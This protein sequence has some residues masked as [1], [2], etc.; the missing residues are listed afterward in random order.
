MAFVVSE[1]MPWHEGENKMHQLTKVGDFDNP[2]S[3]FLQPRAA[4]MVQR[5]PLLAIGTLDKQGRPWAT[6]WGG[7]VPLAQQVAKDIIGIRTI[8]DS[9]TDPVVQ[10][11]YEGKDDGEVIHEQGAGRMISGLSIHLEQRNRMKLFG[12]MVAGAL[13]THEEGLPGSGSVG[14]IQLVVHIEQSLANCPKYLNCKR[15]RPSLPEP[16]L[17]SDSPHL[18]QEA[19][20]LLEK[21]DLFFISSSDHDKDM[22][23]NH[24]GGPPGFVRVESNG[25]QGA[26]LVYPEYSG[27]NLYQTL[28]NLQTSPRAGLCFPDFDTGDVLYVTG[29]TEVLIGKDAAAVLP[30]SY[31]AV[32]IT[33]TGARFV[34]KGLP[35]KGETLE[36]SPYNPTVRYLPSEKA[37]VGD[38]RSVMA[39][40]I[41]NEKL[42]PT[43]FRVRSAISD[44]GAFGPWKP[45]QYAAL[46][47]YDELYMGYS[48]MRN[49]DPKSLNDDYLRT[50]TVSS[51]HGEGLHGEE[52][53]MTIRNVGHVTGFLARQNER[54]HLEVSLRGFAGDFIIDQKPEGITPFIAGGIGIT[55][56]IAQLQDLDISRLRLFWTLGVRDIGLVHDTFRRFPTLP[57]STALFLTGDASLLP[58]ADKKNLEEVGASGAKVE[59]RRMLADDLADLNVEEWYLCTSPGLRKMIQEW[60]PGKKIVYESFD[61]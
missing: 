49:D 52:F 50:F 12:R 55:P 28:G 37:V 42:T 44:P 25:D 20:D 4:S 51:R 54:S 32:R 11:I 9:K 3:P 31:I 60:L 30:R 2:N 21:A 13:N 6:V 10:T 57:Q 27:N 19:L 59:E 18:P 43:I 7:E 48:H 56:L 22:D 26:L 36:R 38:E 14:Q 61:Y 16:R 45:G 35:F 1:A 34:E 23:M 33:L 17:V 39:K 53:E 8:V 58:A 46:S 24:R 15:I 40:L 29:D 41:K 47:F 5:Y